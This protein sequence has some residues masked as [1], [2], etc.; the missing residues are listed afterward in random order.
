M[1]FDCP[2]CRRSLQ[3]ARYFPCFS[4]SPKTILALVASLGTMAAIGG[5]GVLVTAAYAL[6]VARGRRNND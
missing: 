6:T 1:Q 2:I 5:S 3:T 4:R